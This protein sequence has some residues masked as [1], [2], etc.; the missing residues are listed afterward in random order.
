MKKVICIIA[1]MLATPTA[2]ARDAKDATIRELNA[3]VKLQAAH[4]KSLKAQ[5]TDLKSQI[6]AAKGGATTRPAVTTVKP[7]RKP[8]VRPTTPKRKP[9]R[10]EI[11]L[12][13][14]IRK[15]EF[16]GVPLHDICQ[17]MREVSN[18]NIHVRWRSLEVVGIDKSTEVN[19]SLTSMTLE[20]ALLLVL[21]SA[22]PRKLGFEVDQGV[23]VISSRED[24]DKR[25]TSMT[26]NI[27]S[28]V[29]RSS[30]TAASRRIAEV[31]AVIQETVDSSS[32][33]DN[34]GEVGAIQTL[35]GRLVITQNKKN[36][37]AIAELIKILHQRAAKNRARR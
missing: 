21:D 22:A 4:I 6:A 13:K 34:G 37:K 26:Y 14:K 35:G 29:G 7:K 33:R 8:P 28:L 1:I 12:K 5:I 9:V 11:A 2:F 15:M 3:M 18:T 25:T 31:I 27:A 32:W 23:L 36:H 20:R 30:A 10:P 17:W 24:L 19:L 16:K